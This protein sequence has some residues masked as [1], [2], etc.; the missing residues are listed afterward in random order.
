MEK[1]YLII[2]IS[3]RKKEKKINLKENLEIKKK[4]N[5]ENLEKKEKSLKQNLEVKK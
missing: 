4:I 3:Y 5:K 2:G 1:F